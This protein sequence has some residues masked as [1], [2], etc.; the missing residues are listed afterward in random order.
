MIAPAA[1]AAEQ[2]ERQIVQRREADG[3][4]RRQR[5]V[6]RAHEIGR[7]LDQIGI[8]VFRRRARAEQDGEIDAAILQPGL[9]LRPLPFAHRQLDQRIFLLEEPVE[10][11][12]QRMRRRRKIAD[13]HLADGRA[14]RRSHVVRKLIRARHPGAHF[15]RDALPK[16]GQHH[17][18]AG[19]LEQPSAARL[20]KLADPAADVGLARAISERNL[21]EASELGGIDEELPGGVVHASNHIKWDIPEIADLSLPAYP[22]AP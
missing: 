9:E 17:A 13:P 11:A 16:F 21:A 5:I 7:R 8:A 12:H 20:L 2:H 6:C 14:G 18:P 10:R 15:R 1:R 22:P 3:R 19:T 4:P